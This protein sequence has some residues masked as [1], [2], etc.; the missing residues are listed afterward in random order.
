MAV[1]RVRP[2]FCVR[3]DESTF[4]SHHELI[5]LWL[6]PDELALQK[7]E[8]GRFTCVSEFL[9]DV[10]L[11]STGQWMTL[12]HPSLLAVS[13]NRTWWLVGVWSLTEAGEGEGAP[14]KASL[15]CVWQCNWYCA[16]T[17]D[18]LHL[19]R[20]NLVFDGNFSLMQTTTKREWNF[21][22]QVFITQ[23]KRCLSRATG[24]NQNWSAVTRPLAGRS[25]AELLEY[26]SQFA[27][28][29]VTCQFGT[30]QFQH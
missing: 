5:R 15:F 2:L 29:Y 9:R 11:V 7:K 13:G 26:T 22:A 12:H 30:R 27:V 8:K 10:N 19:T 24:G 3:Y 6:P 18:A 20:M 14:Q 1:G 16:F 4:D 17:P 25:Q 21:S 28:Y 23:T